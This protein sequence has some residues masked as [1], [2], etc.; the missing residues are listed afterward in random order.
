[1]LRLKEVNL[2]NEIRHRCAEAPG[3]QEHEVFED[4]EAREN[5]SDVRHT[6]VGSIQ[7]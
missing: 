5:W 7:I 4:M 3:V 1:M 2:V 6:Q